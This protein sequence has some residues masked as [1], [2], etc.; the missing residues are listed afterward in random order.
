[1]TF[2]KLAVEAESKP[3]E[4]CDYSLVCWFWGPTSCCIWSGFLEQRGDFLRSQRGNKGGGVTKRQSLVRRVEFGFSAYPPSLEPDQPPSPLCYPAAFQTSAASLKCVGSFEARCC[5]TYFMRAGWDRVEGSGR[6]WP[7]F[8]Y[9]GFSAVW[10]PT[11]DWFTNNY[12]WFTLCLSG[13]MRC[14]IRWDGS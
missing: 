8:Q 10:I 3:A 7:T 4:T 6:S 13:I 12:F 14:K 5:K 9:A 2:P 1:M 11:K